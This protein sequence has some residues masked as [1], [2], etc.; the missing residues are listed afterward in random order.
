[1]ATNSR[2]EIAFS[3]T[4]T[5]SVTNKPMVVNLLSPTDGSSF[6]SPATVPLS[7]AVTPGTSG[8]AVAVGFYD[9]TNGFLASATVAPFTNSVPL[10]PGIYAIYAVATNGVNE[11][12]YSVTN[13]ITISE[14]PLTIE[15]NSPTNDAVYSWDSVISCQATPT[16]SS[17]GSPVESVSFY[18]LRNGD[19]NVLFTDTSAPYSNQISGLTE[20]TYG[21][22]AVALSADFHIAVSKVSTITIV[23]GILRGPYLGSRGETNINIRWRTSESNVGRVRYGTNA[24]SLIDSADETTGGTNHSLTLTGLAPETRYYYSIG[25]PARTTLASSNYYFKTAPPIGSPRS[26]RI[27]VLSD[28]GEQADE[29]ESTVRDTYLN[30]V[31]I[32]GHPTDVWLTGGDN[33]QTLAGQD[34]LF[35]TGMFAVYSNVLQNTPINPGVGNHDSIADCA[36]WNIFD[37]PYHGQ[38]GGY[39]S[40]SPHYYSFDYANI[41]FINLDSFNAK[42]DP[43]SPLYSWLTNDLSRTTQKWIVANCLRPTA[44]KPPKAKG[45]CRHAMRPKRPWPRFGR[46]YWGART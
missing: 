28:Y 18:S 7:V 43:D 11:I 10:N 8:A 16:L 31:S 15:L 39:P 12:A 40:D 25:T 34:S 37:L 13:T 42:N 44:R 33:E 38:A 9:V 3:T 26:T 46:R 35:Q 4:N 1:V 5:V 14:V 32:S 27:F 23:S 17:S 20:G 24:N 29:M 30:Y 22:F 2:G 6:A 41:H 36:F 21:I 45:R 19:V